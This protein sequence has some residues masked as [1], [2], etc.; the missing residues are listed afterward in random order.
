[1]AKETVSGFVLAGGESSRMGRDKARLDIGGVSLLRRAVGLLQSVTGNSA[2]ISS[3]AVHELSG[4]RTVADD[5]PSWGP[6]GGI[7]TALRISETEWS[8]VIA[9]DL[10]YLT[11]AWLDFLIERALKSGADAVV[12]MNLK[13]PEPLCAVY[14]KNAQQRILA[15]VEGGVHK[16]T[17]SF[18]RLSVEY[19]EPD[20][21]KGFA[22]EGLL[23]KNINS[24]A[25]YEEAKKRLSP[26]S[27]P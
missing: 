25:D 20:E 5:F 11:K 23:F 7:A 27:N 18:D 15:A 1:M 4:S 14:H 12:P 24:P 13:G 22:S 16:V 19:L 6:L 8:L 21:W 2:I 9:C 17:E 3:S 26:L 10:P